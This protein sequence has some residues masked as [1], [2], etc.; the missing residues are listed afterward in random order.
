MENR[1]DREKRE[2][3][4]AYARAKDY[5]ARRREAT[6][7]WLRQ[8]QP[9]LARIASRHRLKMSKHPG[10]FLMTDYGTDVLVIW[11]TGK[12]TVKWIVPV[13]PSL[14]QAIRGVLDEFP[15]G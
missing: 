2:R 3:R 4:K 12:A 9:R 5:A 6:K 15:R 7:E 10:R 1:L 8:V 13:E 14:E 11:W